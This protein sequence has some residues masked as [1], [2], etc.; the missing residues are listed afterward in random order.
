MQLSPW[1]RGDRA[2]VTRTDQSALA[3]VAAH[4]P[5]A[6]ASVAAGASPP[7]STRAA[8][9]AL[10]MQRGADIDTV[11][12]TAAHEVYYTILTSSRAMRK[13]VD[14]V[15]TENMRDVWNGMWD[16]SFARARA[17]VPAGATVQDVLD[18]FRHLKRA[19][20]QKYA[21]PNAIFSVRVV[22]QYYPD[23]A[24]DTREAMEG[25]PAPAG[26]AAAGAAAAAGP[27]GA[28]NRAEILYA[29]ALGEAPF[30][31]R[32]ALAMYNQNTESSLIST[33]LSLMMRDG[34]AFLTYIWGA[35]AFPPAPTGYARLLQD[36]FRLDMTLHPWVGWDDVIAM[37]GWP[38][39]NPR[40]LPLTAGDYAGMVAAPGIVGS[41]GPDDEGAAAASGAATREDVTAYAWPQQTVAHR[42][43]TVDLLMRATGE[44]RDFALAVNG[45]L[46]RH[47]EGNTISYLAT[48]VV[49]PFVLMATVNFVNG[50]TKKS[51]VRV[52]VEAACVRCGT[53]FYVGAEE[54]EP[55]V[56][57]WDWYLPADVPSEQEYS[58]SYHAANT[59]YSDFPEGAVVPDDFTGV[60]PWSPPTEVLRQARIL[61]S[62]LRGLAHDDTTVYKRATRM[63]R[64]IGVLEGLV[65]RAPGQAEYTDFRGWRVD[66]ANSETVPRDFI[67]YLG[68]HSATSRT[69]DFL[70]RFNLQIHP[71]VFQP[72]ASEMISRFIGFVARP[73]AVTAAEE[74]DFNDLIIRRR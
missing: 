5:R 61:H 26:A 24:E 60:F 2:P 4:P 37:P 22:P 13:G 8:E 41:F 38:F 71:S 70:D 47:G 14:E 17:E 42:G 16:R 12:A 25:V 29:R 18:F 68:K 57:M 56:C 11:A 45:E 49:A 21:M 74:R 32:A 50:V 27:V 6:A 53:R 34:R 55:F 10:D 73:S 63:L 3:A 9:A 48:K 31:A 39:K 58:L 52:D 7:L 19:F 66:S 36:A 44:V 35:S 23:L 33:M 15:T 67:R 64:I 65:Q 72:M 46:V 54:A 28:D 62:T 69:P 20:E 43:A 1:S 51:L 59:L 30:R 40:S